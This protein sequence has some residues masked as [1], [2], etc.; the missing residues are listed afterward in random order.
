MALIEIKKLEYKYI[1]SKRLDQKTD[2]RVIFKHVLKCIDLEIEKG[3]KVAIVGSNGAGKSTLLLNIAG[4][5]EPKY[6]QG[7]IYI[8]G[9]EMNEKT[10]YSIREKIGFVFQDPNDQLFSTTVFDDVA[11]GLVNL[12]AKRK[13]PR[14]KDENFIRQRVSDC[15]RAVGLNGVEN[16]V[17]HF[18]SFGE[19]KLAA[20]ATVLSYEPEI[21]ILDEPS[22]NLDP[23]NRE[24]FIKM[25]KDMEKTVIIATHDMDMAY[26]FAG[27]AV[28]INSGRVA[29]DGPAGKVLTDREFLETNSLR[30]PLAL[31]R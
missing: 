1:S 9:I 8:S 3:E 14:S 16:E 31:N 12:L 13:D 15:L 19:K 27:R 5:L 25:L 20:L 10:I 22:S 24:N 18:L 6:R 23:Q 28:L 21:F 29:Y 17:P 4:L 26:E 7:S 2:S 30:L 11:F